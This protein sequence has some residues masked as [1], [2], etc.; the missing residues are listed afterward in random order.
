VLALSECFDDEGKG[1]KAEE[2]DV[3]FFETGEDA[4]IAF[5]AAEEAFDLV[6]FDVER[7][8]VAPGGGAVGLG[9][10]TG[11]I[12]RASTSCLVSSPS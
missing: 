10:T 6:A 12:P 4:A 2:K 3:E 9:G 5:H 1:E 11:I 7:A 8:V